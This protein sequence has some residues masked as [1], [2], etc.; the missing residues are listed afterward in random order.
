MLVKKPSVASIFYRK[1]DCSAIV[2]H[3]KTVP[4]SMKP[5]CVINEVLMQTWEGLWL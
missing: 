2:Q 4:D 5:G 1:L 3:F